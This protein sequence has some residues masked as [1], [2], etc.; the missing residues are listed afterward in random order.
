M[1]RFLSFLAIL[2]LISFPAIPQDQTTITLTLNNIMPTVLELD[3]ESAV[4]ITPADYP[5]V[6]GTIY[7]S[8][9]V[10]ATAT[11]QSAT[12]AEIQLMVSHTSLVSGSDILDFGFGGEFLYVRGT[13][14]FDP[15]TEWETNPV[16]AAQYHKW[17][18]W[19][20]KTGTLSV[21]FKTMQLEP[22]GIYTGT[23]TFQLVE[24]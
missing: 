6:N 18:T 13:G 20:A 2:L 24:N 21:G 3:I 9:P 1:K 12:A 10:N 11:V 14:D 15:G 4:A 5:M 19:G 17:T 23:I 22:D 7:W 16:A 8:A